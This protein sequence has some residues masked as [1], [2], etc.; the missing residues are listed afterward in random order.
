MSS[1]VVGRLACLLRCSLSQLVHAS[2]SVLTA[3]ICWAVDPLYHAHGALPTRELR[4]GIR[5]AGRECTSTSILWTHYARAD[6]KHETPISILGPCVKP[7]SILFATI[8]CA[9]ITFPTFVRGVFGPF[10]SSGDKGRTERSDRI[11]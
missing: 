11:C 10:D 8:P 4:L 2:C 1:T 5:C 6:Q 9:G 7:I 3:D